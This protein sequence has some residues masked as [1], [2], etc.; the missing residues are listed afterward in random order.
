MSHPALTPTLLLILDGW[1]LA[2]A[3]PSNAISM[4]KTL[5]M[6][7]LNAFAPHSQLQASGRAVGLPEGYIGNSEVGHLNIGAGSVVYQDMTRIDVAMENGELEKNPAFVE[8]IQKTLA[9]SK[10]LH[11]AGLLS[12]GGVHSHYKHMQCLVSAAVNAGLEVFIHCFMDGR[13]TKPQGGLE[14]IR[15]LE[16]FLQPLGGKARIA[17][18]C[19]RFYAMDRDTR[20][21]RVQQA[22]NMLV[23][24]K[25]AAGEKNPEHESGKVSATYTVLAS[26]AAEVFDEFIEPT[27]L[28]E[29]GTWQNGDGLFLWNFRADRMRELV[30]AI[31]LPSFDGFDRGPMPCFAGIATMTCYDASFTLPVAFPK[32]N[33]TMGLGEVVS[34]WGCAQLRIAET[35]KY[36]HVTY[37]FNGGREEPFPQEDRILV[38]SPRDVATYD[39]A[40]AMSCQEVTTKCIEALK[41][42]KYTL[43]VCNLANGDMVGHTGK[44]EAAIQACETVDSCVGQFMQAICDVQGRMMIIADHG[45]CESMQDAQGQPQ[46][47]HTT[48]PVP[49]ILFEGTEEKS[50]GHLQNGKLAD[51]APTLIKLWKKD[52]PASMSGVSLMEPCYEKC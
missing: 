14:Y 22:W 26:Y 41:S 32:E 31:T 10:R 9:G 25:C 27:L 4:A 15:T 3:G 40:P 35:E 13:D 12:D 17:S 23:H 45:N 47:S 1:G 43:I 37:F 2:P 30:Q 36:A 50:P 39:L 38:P 8:L 19:G 6:E 5:N 7:M 21:E 16:T 34:S 24:G 18:V 29:D 46:T 48:N 52:I 20:W 33:L 51:V 42:G 28:V 49:C 11:L 44:M